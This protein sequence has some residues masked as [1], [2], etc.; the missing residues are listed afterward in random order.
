[1]LEVTVPALV[2]EP[3]DGNI[4]SYVFEHAAA[5]PERI[6][7]RRRSESGWEKVSAADF[8][9][10]V[11]EL[12]LG[13][14]A[15]G[16]GP[17]DR[18]FLLSAT[19]YE[20]T[21]IDFA[22]WSIGAITVPIYETSAP[23]QISWILADSGA[24]VGF[25]ETAA[26]A[27][28]IQQAK[29]AVAPWVLAEGAL[30]ELSARAG[31]VAP[32]VAAERTAQLKPSDLATIIYTSGTT[33][34]PKGCALTHG[35]FMFLADNIVA[36]LP[37]I[38][39]TPDAA[40]LLFLTLAHVFARVIQ[41]L[42]IRAGAQLGHTAD[43]KNLVAE[44]AEFQPTFFLAVPRVFEK[45]YNSTEAKAQAAGR[46]RIFSAA[47]A[48]AIRYSQALDE[49]SVPPSL[50]L[51]HAIADRLVF[52]KL[53]AALG[54]QLRHAV[55][56]G[57]PL[58]ERLGHFFRGV[59]ICVLEGYG[60]TETTAPS[61]VNT[62]DC[63]RMGSVG[64]PLPGVSIALADDG[65]VLIRGPHIFQGYHNDPAETATV[66]RA[67]WFHTGDLGYLDN[68]I[69][70][71][72][73]RKKEV[74]VTSG[75]KNVAPAALE[76]RLRAHPLIS[77]CLVVGDQR[78][79]IAALLTLDSEMLPIW[80][81]NHG[82]DSLSS[83]EAASSAIVRSELDRAIAA[84]N[85]SVSKAE[86]IRNFGILAED[87]TETA[88]HLTPSLKVKRHVIIAEYAETIDSLY[89]STPTASTSRP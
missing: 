47:A 78:P 6:L 73:G 82:H 62:P 67:G 44:L 10:Q 14:I 72:T 41:V 88:G 61:T 12:G 84:A 59:G 15:A 80:L 39:R 87:F 51:Q 64:A 7:L 32:A 33:G 26:H 35:N 54:G 9:R 49:N 66:L 11:T 57:A 42:A 24:Q 34:R 30:A 75:G 13:L 21:L 53:R 37:V 86:S 27:H 29:T 31:S 81:K 77:Q 63:T 52:R 43:L 70:T 4:S 56:G 85:T 36:H 38:L 71:I 89:R 83:A 58:G 46:G 22:I 65:E 69:L 19:C 28:L 20:W 25:A 40:T 50:R 55:S 17:G 1:M 76:D 79:Y 18:V 8:A 74:I 48:I 2:A 23:E 3:M 5:T 16:V 68:D 45:I 60:L